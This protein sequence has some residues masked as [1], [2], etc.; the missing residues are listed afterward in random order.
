[1]LLKPNADFYSSHH[2]I[3]NDVL[4]LIEVA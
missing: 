1:M 2:P 3:A 4:L